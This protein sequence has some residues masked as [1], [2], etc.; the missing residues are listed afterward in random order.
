M[1]GRGDS[2][3][4]PSTRVGSVASRDDLG[5]RGD[6]HLTAAFAGH[7]A[8]QIVHL[9]LQDDVLMGVRLV[10]QDDGRRPG[11]EEC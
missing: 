3:K 5:M 6:E 1:S 8:N 7:L 9:S 11:V 2:L 10:E 4:N